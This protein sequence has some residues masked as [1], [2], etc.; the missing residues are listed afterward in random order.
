MTVQVEAH[1]PIVVVVD[2]SLLRRK[3]EVAEP[4]HRDVEGIGGLD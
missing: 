1:E 4:V 3:D 2:A